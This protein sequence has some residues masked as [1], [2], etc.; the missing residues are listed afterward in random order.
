MT[1][2]ERDLELG[3]F[4][5]D[6]NSSSGTRKSLSPI[7][8]PLLLSS[9]VSE[10]ASASTQNSWLC[11]WPKWM[12][13]L[14]RSD[15]TAGF[16]FLLGGG[17]S[18]L[19]RLQ[20]Y[21]SSFQ[22]A[23]DSL[24]LLSSAIG[25]NLRFTSKLSMK[26][27][28]LAGQCKELKKDMVYIRASILVKFSQGGVPE[29]MT[30]LY[31]HMA[32]LIIA[33]NRIHQNNSKKMKKDLGL[34]MTYAASLVGT[35]VFS[36]QESNNPPTDSSNSANGS[37][38]QSDVSDMQPSWDQTKNFA[39]SGLNLACIALN[40]WQ[41]KTA[42]DRKKETKL[43]KNYAEAVH[44]LVN[45][46]GRTAAVNFNHHRYSMVC[47]QIDM[48]DNISTEILTDLDLDF[49]ELNLII[50]LLTKPEN[51]N[52]ISVKEMTI[53]ALKDVYVRIL[54]ADVGNELIANT[55]KE[56]C[57]TNV[58]SSLNVSSGRDSGRNQAQLTQLL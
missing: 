55:H 31:D 8:H 15:F 7:L 12:P 14:D 33:Q 21:S 48:S 13:K 29:D 53:K 46:N 1:G 19:T 4:E 38:S 22:M 26:V 49:D 42:R 50:K 6:S 11:R 37:N 43:F 10:E 27:P 17:M 40:L 32:N 24:G 52:G 9:D 18:T 5:G 57:D 35:L 54:Q 25:V 23:W 28:K 16:F 44:S 34:L 45:F 3:P 56:L 2:K 39:L 20:A 41:I 58:R 51:N 30:K 47:E 36:M